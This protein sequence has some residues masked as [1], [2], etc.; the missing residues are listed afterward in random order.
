MTLS[1]IKLRKTSINQVI[2]SKD[3]VMFGLRSD[4]ETENNP[5]FTNNIDPA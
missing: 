5:T 4:D 2:D 3:S 1:P